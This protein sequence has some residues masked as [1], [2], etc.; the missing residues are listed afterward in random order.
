MEKG[1]EFKIEHGKFAHCNIYLKVVESNDVANACILCLVLIKHLFKQ[2]QQ[3]K[4][5][6]FSTFQAI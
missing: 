4:K 3:S 1:K 6:N 5:K 2:Q